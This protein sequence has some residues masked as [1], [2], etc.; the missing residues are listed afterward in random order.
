MVTTEVESLSA[1][2]VF[3]AVVGSPVVAVLSDRWFAARVARQSEV[4]KTAFDSAVDAEVQR[5]MATQS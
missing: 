3:V 2:F 4:Q 1:I 5:R